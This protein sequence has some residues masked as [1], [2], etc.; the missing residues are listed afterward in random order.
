MQSQKLN[1]K[2]GTPQTLQPVRV[3]GTPIYKYLCGF[4]LGLQI[5]LKGLTVDK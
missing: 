4:E 1:N 5:F 2:K 3:V